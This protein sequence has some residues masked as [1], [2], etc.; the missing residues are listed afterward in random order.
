VAQPLRDNLDRHAGFGKQRGVCVVITGRSG[1]RSRW[2]FPV[3]GSRLTMRLF[4]RLTAA[5][6]VNCS[7]RRIRN[8]RRRPQRSASL[9]TR[10][11]RGRPH[12]MLGNVTPRDFA[13]AAPNQS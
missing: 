3:Q 5:F 8:D 4:S 12:S 2:T 11:Q 10:I 13:V 6:V 1:T 7:V 9:A